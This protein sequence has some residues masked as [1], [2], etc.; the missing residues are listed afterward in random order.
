M[1]PAGGSLG[2][3]VSKKL[4]GENFMIWKAQVMPAIRGAMLAGYL[5]GSIQEPAAEIVTK[6]D[7]G[8]EVKITNPEYARWISQ[9]QTV[10]GYLSGI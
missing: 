3:S 9:D 5:D 1:A 2:E 7:D 8:K 10:L 6:D 4:T